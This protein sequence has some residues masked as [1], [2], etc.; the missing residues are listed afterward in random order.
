MRFPSPGPVRQDPADRRRA[1]P[2]RTARWRSSPTSTWR[3]TGAPG[4]PSSAS[5]A[6]ARPPCCG[7]SAGLL[8][9]DTG[10][11]HAGHGLRLGYYAQEHE[12][13]DVERTILEHMR[14]AARRADRH[15]AA[16]DPRRVPVLRRRRRQAGRGALRRRED[17]AGA[18]HAGLLRRQRAAAGRADEQPRPD[19]PRAGARRDRPLPRRDRAGHPRPGRGARRSSRTGRS[20][21][22]TASRTP[23]ATTCWSWSSWPERLFPMGRSADTPWEQ[24]STRAWPGRAS[25]TI[26]VSA[27]TPTSS[28]RRGRWRAALARPGR[29]RPPSA[30]G[31][32]AA[33]RARR[34]PGPGRPRSRT[35]TAAPAPTRNGQPGVLRILRA[36]AHQRRPGGQQQRD[37]ADR[38]PTRSPSGTARPAARSR[39]RA[40]SRPVD[41]LNPAEL[42]A[43]TGISA[44][45]PV[46]TLRNGRRRAKYRQ[47][48]DRPSQ[49]AA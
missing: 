39:P 26:A 21:C 48:T 43:S 18:G 22:P 12:T 19:Q 30:R 41:Q 42:A 49:G 4:W 14:S 5:T 1:C 7:C 11:V 15:R 13:L 37:H 20:C 3:W 8:Q 36:L 9:P 40:I 45:R 6:P 23:G 35:R 29:P 46:A 47:T 28:E 10:E 38:R 31:R 33:R 24:A 25:M 16:Q 2:S 34:R 32:T 27:P 17:P 44:P